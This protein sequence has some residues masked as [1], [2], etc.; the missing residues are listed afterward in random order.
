MSDMSDDV[1][2]GEKL[3]ANNDV[4]SGKLGSDDSDDSFIGN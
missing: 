4:L 3:L 2:N 1:I